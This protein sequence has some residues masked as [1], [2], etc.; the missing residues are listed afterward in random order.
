MIE[1][2]LE[3]QR[4]IIL[5]LSQRISSVALPEERPKS[6]HY[7]RSG[8]RPIGRKTSYS[9]RGISHSASYADPR[10]TFLSS[11]DYPSASSAR[12]SGAYK[13]VAPSLTSGVQV[14]PTDPACINSLLMQGSNVLL[15]H[16]IDQFEQM[17]RRACEL[18]DLVSLFAFCHPTF[19]Y[20]RGTDHIIRLEH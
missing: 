20:K 5:G 2:T 16:K 3:Q 13:A 6:T 8:S 14:D 4:Q 11:Y 15:D 7:S 12:P 10:D 1:R 18:E 17:R 9:S 19:V